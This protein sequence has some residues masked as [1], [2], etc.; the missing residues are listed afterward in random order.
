MRAQWLPA[1]AGLFCIALASGRPAQAQEPVLDSINR[2][3]LAEI[4]RQR[5]PGL[6]LAVLQGDRVLL[7]RGYGLS[8]VELGVPASD[9]T[10]YQ[11]GSLGKQFTAS[12]VVILSQQRRLRLDDKIV[13][14]L[15]EGGPK[16]SAITVQHLLTHTS[17]MREYTDST[18][19]YRRDYTEDQ[20]V[21]F[22]ASRPLDFPPGERWAYSNTGYVLL[23]ALIHR[24][25]GRLYGEV[26]HQLLFAPL[27]MRTTRIISESDL[28]PNRASGYQ[29]VRG[30]IQNQEWVAPSLNTTADGSLY[31]GIK[32]LIQWAISLNHGRIPDSSALSAAWSPVRLKDG[33]LYPYGFGWDL[34]PQRGHRRIGHTGSWQGFKSAMYRYPEYGITVIALANL[35]QGK[36]G[37]I[38]EGVAGILEPAL[39]PASRL[40]RALEP[41]ASLPLEQLL[42]KIVRNEEGDAVTPGL[43]RFMSPAARHELGQQ[44][45]SVRSWTPL[46]CDDLSERG[47][48]WLRAAVQR[49]CYLKGEGSEPILASVFYTADW[50]AALLD[51]EPY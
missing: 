49:V 43:R 1:G 13:K 38:A 25:T 21:R 48:F 10:I 29:L 51:V 45:D 17:G 33:G 36:P 18:F 8:N 4:N 16:W 26:L 35:A 23:G 47:I 44:M 28:V 32:D 24:L 14:W 2:Y 3:V 30:R 40:R 15:P 46:G 6:S 9:S 7:A 34:L 19:D 20:L 37:T 31:F 39:E 11:S 27:G 5:I 12:A 41:H 42:E 22:A 50:Q